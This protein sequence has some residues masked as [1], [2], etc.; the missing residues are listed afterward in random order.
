MM[1]DEKVRHRPNYTTV[2][3]FSASRMARARSTPSRVFRMI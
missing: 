3:V 1:V 2:V